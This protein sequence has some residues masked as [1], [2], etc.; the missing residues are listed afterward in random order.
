MKSA[1]HTTGKY[2]VG[3]AII[4]SAGLMV[5]ARSVN[6]AANNTSKMQLTPSI[7][8]KAYP[9]PFSDELNISVSP[10]GKRT[11]TFELRSVDDG[12]V[13]LHETI[14]YARMMTLNTS[15]VPAGTYRLFASDERGVVAS[16]REIKCER[17]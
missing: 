10:Y 4:V 14:S 11:I 5:N 16:T 2:L 13:S 15:N 6:T 7:S 1:K 17:E 8:I 9:N 12:H 3:L